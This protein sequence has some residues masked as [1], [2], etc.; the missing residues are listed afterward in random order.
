MVIG[1]CSGGDG[2]IWMEVDLIDVGFSLEECI[3]DL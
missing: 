1:K 2:D 3:D